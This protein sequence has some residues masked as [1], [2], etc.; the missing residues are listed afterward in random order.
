MRQDPEDPG[1]S[2]IIR[3]T[4]RKRPPEVTESVIIIVIIRR[5]R[6]L[7]LQLLISVDSVKISIILCLALVIFVVLFV[8]SLLLSVA[9]LLENPCENFSQQVRV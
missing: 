9:A 2:V 7:I 3:N 4:K 8:W 1:P 6:R 5:S